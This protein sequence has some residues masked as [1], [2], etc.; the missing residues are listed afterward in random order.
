[1]ILKARFNASIDTLNNLVSESGI[2]ATFLTAPGICKD[3]SEIVG[4]PG[5]VMTFIGFVA[6]YESFYALEHVSKV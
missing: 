4:A 1:M 2:D 5:A 6:G 3:T